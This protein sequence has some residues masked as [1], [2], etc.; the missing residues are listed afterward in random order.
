MA[1]DV[2]ARGLDIPEI[3]LVVNCE[4]PKDHLTYIHRS[5]RAGRAGRNGVCITFFTQMQQ[6]QIRNIETKAKIKM[7]RIGTPQPED[8]IQASVTGAI[9][10]LQKVDDA[11]IPLFMD[12]AKKVLAS[13]DPERALAAALA[14]LTG[15]TTPMQKRSLLASVVGHTT[16]MVKGPTP[17]QSPRYAMTIIAGFLNESIDAVEFKGVRLTKNGGAVADIPSKFAER[18]KN[19]NKDS[20]Y[21]NYEFSIPTELPEII[22]SSR[23]ERPPPRGRFGGGRGGGYGGNRFGGRSGGG[24][25][26]GNRSGGGGGGFRGGRRY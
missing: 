7:P 25:G 24:Y 4:P 11:V 1:T 8:L 10:K 18:F 22:D 14:Q 9:S 16:V 2:A 12:A 15:Y 21:N 5:G 20:R 19:S 17:I 6:Y 26:G 13:T 3:D 23:D